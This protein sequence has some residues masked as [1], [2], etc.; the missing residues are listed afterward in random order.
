MDQIKLETQNNTHKTLKRILELEN[1]RQLIENADKKISIHFNTS[2][3]VKY[4]NKVQMR[5]FSPRF[6]FIKKKVFFT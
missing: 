5:S 1:A 2:K 6:L 3:L 4:Q